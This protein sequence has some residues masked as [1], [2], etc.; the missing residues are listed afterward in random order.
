MSP[1]KSVAEARETRA[2]ILD[3]SVAIASVE[4]LDGLTIGRL[5]L[6]LGM[7]KAGVLGHFG[8]KE[9]L[10]LAA[11]R[12]ASAV[13]SR[14]VWEPN[15]HLDAGL[16]RL[17]GV[18]ESWADYL[19]RARDHFP[20]GCLFTT[21]A[22]EYDARSGPVRDAITR[23]TVF[24]QHRRLGFDLRAAVALGE[25]RPDADVEQLVFELTG[26]YLSLNQ[27]VQLNQAADAQARAL[28]A[29]DRLL[30]LEAPVPG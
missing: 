6:D 24:W 11:L 13:F 25:L 20:G 19:V 14:L 10:Q 23:L 3:R 21:A 1:R 27:A 22:V 5:A 9:A 28:R 26:I 17:H 15:A 4:G 29:V 16:P 18:C 2:R 30:A 8:T 12:E 7:S